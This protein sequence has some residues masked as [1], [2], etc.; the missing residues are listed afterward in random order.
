MM[1]AMLA[2][3]DKETAS[4]A[5]FQ[6][7]QSIPKDHQPAAAATALQ[8]QFTRVAR[9]QARLEWVADAAASGTGSVLEG[10]SRLRS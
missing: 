3:A 9:N 7:P 5:L 4:A 2:Q 8:G 1:M 10:Y 6:F